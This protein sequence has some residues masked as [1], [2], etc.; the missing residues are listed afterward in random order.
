MRSPIII[1]DA[2]GFEGFYY[3]GDHF[4]RI[5][6]FFKLKK[7][8][9]LEIPSSWGILRFEDGAEVITINVAA[10]L[11]SR[12]VQTG[13]LSLIESLTYILLHELTHWAN[14]ND[15]EKHR[16]RKDG[17]YEYFHRTLL[18]IVKETSPSKKPNLLRYCENEKNPKGDNLGD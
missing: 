2:P 1:Q 10:M 8:G 4:P 14:D 12:R 13:E 5:G 15:N 17:C 18:N 9:W 7:T 6:T 16:Y 11:V 3:N